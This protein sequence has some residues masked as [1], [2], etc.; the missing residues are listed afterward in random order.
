MEIS[1]TQQVFL[2]GAYQHDPDMWTPKPMGV[3]FCILCQC[4]EYALSR[5]TCLS[6]QVTLNYQCI[7][8]GDLDL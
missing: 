8:H 2:H 1:S 5:P 6:D 7:G 4:M 3:F